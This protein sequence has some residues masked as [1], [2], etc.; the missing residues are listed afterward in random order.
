[1]PVTDHVSVYAKA[2]DWIYYLMSFMA[3]LALS[4]HYW[5][6]LKKRWAKR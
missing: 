1:V 3:V 6:W 4:W 2:G 5:Q